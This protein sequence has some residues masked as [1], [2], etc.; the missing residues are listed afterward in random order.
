MIQTVKKHFRAS[1]LRPEINALIG[2]FMPWS[3][4]DDAYIDAL[5]PFLYGYSMYEVDG[6]FKS[7]IPQSSSVVEE[8]TQ[9]IRMLFRLDVAALTQEI[10]LGMDQ[11][12]FVRARACDYLRAHERHNVVKSAKANKRK[13]VYEATELWRNQLGFFIFGY[14]VFLFSRNIEQLA[15]AGEIVK[16]EDEIWVT[17]FANVELDRLSYIKQDIGVLDD[18]IIQQQ[19]LLDIYRRCLHHLLEQADQGGGEAAASLSGMNSIHETRSQIQHIKTTLRSYG[20]VVED[21]PDDEIQP[22]V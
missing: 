9:V 16:P 4:Y 5:R 8:R 10:G 3:N 21:H 13:K 17:N 11:F 7:D 20:V 19:N 12:N 18:I 2:R 1:A 15:N 22:G 14:L 6:V